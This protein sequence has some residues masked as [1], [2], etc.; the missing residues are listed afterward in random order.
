MYNLAVGVYLSLN[1][2]II[3]NHGYVVISDIGSNDDTALICHTNR[4]ATITDIGG[5]TN[6][7]GDWFAPNGTTVGFGSNSIVS[8]FRRTRGPMMVRLL[9]NTAT[10]PPSEGIYHCLVEDDTLTVQTVYVGLYNSGGGIY[11]Y[12]C[13]YM[14]IIA[15]YSCVHIYLCSMVCWLTFTGHIT[16]SDNVAFA[17]DS[18]ASDSRLTFTLTCISTG[19]P[20]TTVTWTRNSDT[21]TEGTETV[22]DDP[23][24]AQYNHTLTVT[25]RLGGLYTCTVANDKPSHDSAQLSVQGMANPSESTAKHF[26]LF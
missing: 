23:V 3:P 5:S 22:L 7:G 18:K 20:A 13:T 11:V 26:G 10:D 24:T 21:V 4:P 8:G 25:G 15:M 19:G 16:I 2:D 1:D 6:S 14:C 17:L 12:M 9:R